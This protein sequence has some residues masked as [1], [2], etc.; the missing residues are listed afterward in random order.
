M[1]R[2]NVAEPFALPL[3]LNRRNKALTGWIVALGATIVYLVSNHV[4]LFTPRSLPMWALDEAIPFWPQTVWIYLSEYAVIFILFMMSKDDTNAN[5]FL[6]A[7]ASL[8]VV[9]GII[10][11]LWPTT[12]PRDL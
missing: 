3:F 4:H 11:V 5:K 6:Y 1:V 10:F 9:C 8:Q 12:Y 7:F 2:M